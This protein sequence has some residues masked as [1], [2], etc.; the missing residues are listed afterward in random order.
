MDSKVSFFNLDPCSRRLQQVHEVYY[1]PFCIRQK[2]TY[3]QAEKNNTPV[4]GNAGDEKNLYPG[5]LKLIFLNQFSGEI[6][7]ILLQFLFLFC[8]L[9]FF[10]FVLITCL[11]EIKNIY[12]D[13][14]SNIGQVTDKESF[15]RLISGNKTTFFLL[16]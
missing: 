9:F 4:S 2:H 10:C 1:W 5:G 14:H 12:S 8:I 6:F 15:I 11:F 3:C 7:S 16:T 13:T